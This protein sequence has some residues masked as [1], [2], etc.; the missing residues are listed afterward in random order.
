[1]LAGQTRPRTA[2]A[3][4]GPP[5]TEALASAAR[6]KAPTA[7]EPT[8]P[9]KTPT[10]TPTRD[11]ATYR[12]SPNAEAGTGSPTPRT[13]T[14]RGG[15]TAAARCAP[16]APASRSGTPPAPRPEA[17]TTWPSRHP[18]PSPARWPLQRPCRCRNPAPRRQR[19]RG[20]P[21]D[22]RG[23]VWSAADLRKAAMFYLRAQEVRT[24]RAGKA[25]RCAHVQPAYFSQRVDQ[26][27]HEQGGATAISPRVQGP[28]IGTFQGPGRCPGARRGTGRTRKDQEGHAVK[29]RDLWR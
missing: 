9:S 10:T 14:R 28:G 4:S 7:A 25:L 13:C 22:Q 6:G 16:S 18:R 19:E 24:R 5:S 20:D 8:K 17:D 23:T 26:G 12:R 1:M 27:L 11:G 15:S 3:T 2:P 21:A 29:R